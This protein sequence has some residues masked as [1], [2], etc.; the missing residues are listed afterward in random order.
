[1]TSLVGDQIGLV[2][3]VS[4]FVMTQSTVWQL[5]IVRNRKACLAFPGSLKMHPPGR[6]RWH[7]NKQTK[8]PLH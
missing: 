1:M 2:V 7:R 4:R 5:T 6:I 8:K 3:F